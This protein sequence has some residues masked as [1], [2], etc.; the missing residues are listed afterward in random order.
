M[1]LYFSHY[2]FNDAGN[3]SDK[4]EDA[5]GSFSDYW[6]LLILA[7]ALIILVSSFAINADAQPGFSTATVAVCEEISSSIY[8]HDEIKVICGDESYILPRTES[9]ASCGS[10]KMDV[11][12]I[13]GAA[14]FTKD[15][16][17]PRY[18]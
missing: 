18:E 10:L 6:A 14:F 8:C 12:I 16:K 17:D 4:T 5:T 13:T 1:D 15:W 7:V 2:L 3:I 11:L 9:Q